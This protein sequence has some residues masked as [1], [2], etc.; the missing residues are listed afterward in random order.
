MLRCHHI[1]CPTDALLRNNHHVQ[2]PICALSLSFLS[3]LPAN[4]A[5]ICMQ[6]KAAS[7][8]SP[9]ISSDLTYPFT[10]A[11]HRYKLIASVSLQ[12]SLHKPGFTAIPAGRL[13]ASAVASCTSFRCPA[14]FSTII[15]HERVHIFHQSH[16]IMSPASGFHSSSLSTTTNLP[17]SHPSTVHSHIH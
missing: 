3:I 11:Y 4:P 5:K 8:S 13:R 9:C 12:A 17:L 16:G 6:V 1:P 7:L 14:F 2:V 15:E 10:H